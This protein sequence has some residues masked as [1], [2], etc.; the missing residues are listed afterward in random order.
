MLNIA[1]S[2]D[3]ILSTRQTRQQFE[4]EAKLAIALKF[5]ADERLSLG[6]AADF[7][8]LSKTAFIGY[9]GNNH[10]SIFRFKDGADELLQDA[11]NA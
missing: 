2:D 10:I 11:T 9:L 6:Q 3:F 5:Y 4:H 7:A 1:I 8:G